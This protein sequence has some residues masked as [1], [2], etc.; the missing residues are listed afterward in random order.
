[1]GS[2]WIDFLKGLIL[3]L[4]HSGIPSAEPNVINDS[5]PID[6]LL[7]LLRK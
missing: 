2:D 4:Y 6:L 7:N 3:K 5:D 1:M